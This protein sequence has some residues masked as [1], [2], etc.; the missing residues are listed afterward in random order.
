MIETASSETRDRLALVR[1]DLANERTLLAYGRTGLMVTGTG[2]TLI[3]FFADSTVPPVI[4]WVLIVSGA[5][6][7]I[8][9]V[10]R[11]VSLNRRL[12]G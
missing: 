5:I 8:I 11:F 4:G 7:G 12:R 10:V 3:K 9:G 6:I 2:A 1:T